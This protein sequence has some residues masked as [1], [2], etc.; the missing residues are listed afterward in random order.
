MS[1]PDELEHTLPSD[2][3]P[4]FS[5]I[6]W[7]VW[8]L[9]CLLVIAVVWVA[10]LPAK[11]DLS[12]QPPEVFPG[13]GQR[14]D[15]LALEPLVGTESPLVASDL[16]GK[17]VLLNLWGP[18]CMYCHV[19][20]PHLVEM[21]QQH[22]SRSDFQ[23]V[24]VSCAAPGDPEDVELLRSDTSTTLQ[25]RGFAFPVH[26]DREMMTRRALVEATVATGES[27]SFGYPTT[28][29]LDREGVIRGYWTG[30]APGMEQEVATVLNRVLDEPAAP[31]G[32]A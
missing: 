32:P 2:T 30:F 20:M 17:V 5:W 19:E 4:H 10:V 7:G 15:G 6:S 25:E 3:P 26:W 21:Y 22:R 31:P 18:W 12:T 29:V 16:R 1:E 28:V 13:K 24:S 8:G 23:F 14:L 9:L 11:P 27:G